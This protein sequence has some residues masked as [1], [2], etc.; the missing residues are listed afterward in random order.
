MKRRD[1]VKLTATGLLA[2]AMP[3]TFPESA[4]A[5]NALINMGFKKSHDLLKVSV[6]SFKGSDLERTFEVNQ[7]YYNKKGWLRL[8]KYVKGKQANIYGKDYS[9]LVEW[10]PYEM[11]PQFK[12]KRFDICTN[13]E[14]SLIKSLKENTWGI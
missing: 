12:C 14:V 9:W 8:M 5:E 2:L 10:R 6:G 13:S 7:S 4:T 11:H 1:F 3:W